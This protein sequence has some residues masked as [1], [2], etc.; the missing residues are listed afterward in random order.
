[1]LLSQDKLDQVYEALDNLRSRILRANRMEDK[2]TLD[3][4]LSTLGISF[5]EKEVRNEWKI[6]LCAGT[7][8]SKDIIV[9]VLGDYKLE[10]RV[11]M[12]LDYKKISSINFDKFRDSQTYKYIVFGQGPHKAKGIGKYGS[13]ISRMQSE[14]EHYPDVIVM[15]DSQDKPHLS[16]SELHKAMQQIFIKE[17][18][19]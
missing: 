15:T 14:P 12:E 17:D 9:K 1:M 16:V 6:Y 8:I 7:D 11:E 3:S 2:S 5:D 4:L 13:I 18:I 19:E 10:D